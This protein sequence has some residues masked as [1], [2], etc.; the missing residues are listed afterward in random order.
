MH[1]C[2]VAKML[3]T[4]K[5]LTVSTPAISVKTID[6]DHFEIILLYTCIIDPECGI[7]VFWGFGHL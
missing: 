2:V 6:M 4:A 5:V 3:Y 1:A 7:V